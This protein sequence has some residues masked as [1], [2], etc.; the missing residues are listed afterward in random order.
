MTDNSVLIC[1]E[2][3]IQNFSEIVDYQKK[4]IIL[5]KMSLYSFQA[6]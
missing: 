6:T 2:K 1:S 4:C 3:N 5:Q